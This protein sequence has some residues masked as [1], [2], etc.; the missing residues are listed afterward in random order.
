MPRALYANVFLLID[1]SVPSILKRA[2]GK[3]SSW[4]ASDLVLEAEAHSEWSGALLKVT[5]LVSGRAGAEFR[6]PP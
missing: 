4:M 1:T 3:S 5:E 2:R 6:S